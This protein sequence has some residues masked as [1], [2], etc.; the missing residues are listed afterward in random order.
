[1]GSAIFGGVETAVQSA[2]N[3]N[4]DAVKALSDQ[5]QIQNLEE[6][7]QQ[8]ISSAKAQVANQRFTGVNVMPSL[9]TTTLQ[10]V[11]SASF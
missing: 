7:K 11:T 6:Q 5:T 9:D 8:Q 3:P 2:N 4:S 10:N 1:M